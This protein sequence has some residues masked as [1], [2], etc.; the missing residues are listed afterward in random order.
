MLTAAERDALR[1]LP[2]AELHLHLE[3]TLTPETLWRLAQRQG[4]PHGLAS[5]DACRELYH[6]Q[7]FG[8]FIRAIKTASQLLVSPADYADAVTALA[9]QLR[10]QGVVYAE[11]FLSIGILLWRQ[12][13]IEPYWEAV[14]A[15]RLA[16]ERETGVR[17]AWL[18][19][20]VRQFGPEPFAQVVGWAIKLQKSGQ[21]VGIGVGGDETQ[22]ATAEFATGYA[23][24][25]DAGLHTTI[26]A[27]E[28]R[29][30][31]SVREALRHLRPERIGHGLNAFRDP[32]LVAELADS[33]VSL[34]ICHISNLR[35]GAWPDPSR[36]HPT[37]EYFQRG[38][39]FAVSTDDPGIFGVSLTDEY[40]YMGRICGFNPDEI[41]QV[42]EAAWDYS[43]LPEIA[44]RAL[45]GL[46]GLPAADAGGD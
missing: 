16:A 20:A 44:R 38:V 28:T 2:K 10:A 6:F 42:T 18:F 21:V 29:G 17:I 23:R 19:D 45:A 5:L 25:R 12:V 22:V 8:G 26:H 9:R 14:E 11:V 30:P 43:F 37:R 41:R 32:E 13:Q 34:D 31:E 1:R 46:P 40:D 24:A 15:A 27:G 33:P 35:T 36:P 7:D 39:R 3:G 4:Q